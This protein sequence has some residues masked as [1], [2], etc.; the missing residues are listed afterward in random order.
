MPTLRTVKSLDRASHKRTDAAWFAERCADKTSRTLILV[1]LKPAIRTSEARDEAA[2]RWFSNDDLGKFGLAQ[3]PRCFLGLDTAGTAHFSMAISEHRAVAVPEGPFA[4]R[5][6][7]DLRTLAVQGQLTPEELSM[8][9][10]ARSLAEWHAH[11]R[12]CGSCG[13]ATDIRDGG[14]KRQCFACKKEVFPRTDPVVIMLVTHK[15]ECLISHEPRFKA[16]D[17]RMFSILAGFLEPGEDIE[18][19]VRREVRE[20]VGLEV[21]AVTYQESQPWPFPHSLMIGCR[22]EAKSK[23]LTLDPAEIAEARWVGRDE[24]RLILDRKHPEK[25]TAPGQHAIALK[26]LKRFLAGK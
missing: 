6:F 7:V 22:A 20:E 18:H 25:I 10:A 12:H 8:V 5:P 3:W 21:G 24:L 13:S 16:Y 1:D 9:G 4:L 26:L 23:K 11:T 15:D 14:W 19:A 2:L 17:E